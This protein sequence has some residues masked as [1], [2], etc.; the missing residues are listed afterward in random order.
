MENG[1]FSTETEDKWLIEE[2]DSKPTD[3]IPSIF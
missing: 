1:L 3:T 2:K